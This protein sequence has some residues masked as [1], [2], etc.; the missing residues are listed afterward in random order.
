MLKGELIAHQFGR[1]CQC[2]LN[3]CL[4][5]TRK[6]SQ[7]GVAAIAGAQKFQDGL[8]GDAGAR[9]GR[10]SV[11][12]IWVDSD[13]FHGVKYTRKAVVVALAKAS[14]VAGQTALRHQRHY[15]RP[16]RP[17]SRT[18]TLLSLVLLSS[19]LF[20]QV[21]VRKGDFLQANAR[22]LCVL[23]EITARRRRLYL[24]P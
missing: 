17:G 2:R 14:E 23:D 3:I 13:V 20:Q 1:K 9:N 19:P 15:Q 5:Q 16:H 12:N 21:A 8:H 6:L 24:L 7:N 4:C 10:A 18:T 11:A 22:R